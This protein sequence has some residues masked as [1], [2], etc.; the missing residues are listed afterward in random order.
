M[1]PTLPLVSLTDIAPLPEKA[2]PQLNTHD[3]K[4]EEDE[5]AEQQHIPQHGQSV[6]Q[7]H[8]QNSHA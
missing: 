1:I 2:R 5:E 3:T 8:H 4:D 7:Q 6:K